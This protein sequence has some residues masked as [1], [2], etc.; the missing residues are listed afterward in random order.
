MQLLKPRQ[1]HVITARKIR[2]FSDFQAASRYIDMRLA[3]KPSHLFNIQQ[4]AQGWTVSR[5][6][7][8]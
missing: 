3:Q 4:T 2:V 1:T 8:V 7:G 6:I 5:V